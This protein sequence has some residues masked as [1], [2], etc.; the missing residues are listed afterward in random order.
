MAQSLYRHASSHI[1]P[2]LLVDPVHILADLGV[3]PGLVLPAAAVPSGRLYKER[4]IQDL[5]PAGESHK[6]GPGFVE[7]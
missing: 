1:S 6:R 7:L 2:G 5:P 4:K 3:H